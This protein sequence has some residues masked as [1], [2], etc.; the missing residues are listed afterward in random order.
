MGSLG[1][2]Q[3]LWWVCLARRG[4]GWGICTQLSL[5]SSQHILAGMP[6]FPSCLHHLSP[7]MRPVA[8]PPPHPFGSSPHHP[9]P[10]EDNST[11]TSVSTLYTPGSLLK[12]G[13][14]SAFSVEASVMLSGGTRFCSF[15]FYFF[16]ILNL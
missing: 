13:V 3:Q 8:T 16:K 14:S 2:R 4:W 11:C 15:A 9:S 10:A 6:P 1:V 12:A 7:R 5:A